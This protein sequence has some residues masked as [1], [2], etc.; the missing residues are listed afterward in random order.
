MGYKGNTTVE[1]TRPQRS[2]F[3]MSQERRLS[4]RMGRLTQVYCA[5]VLPGDYWWGKTEIMMRLAPLLAPIFARVNVFVHWHFVPNRLLWKDWEPFITGGRLGAEVSV[6]PVPPNVTLGFVGGRAKSLMAKSTLSNYLGIPPMLD[7]TAIAYGSRSIDLMPFAANY[8]IW[9]DWYRDRNYDADDTILPLP[10]G[11]NAVAA[12][13]DAL[14][15]TRKRSWESDYF[16]SAQTGTQ[17]GSE[18]LMPI[19]A[20]GNATPTYLAQAT[21]HDA[22]GSLQGGLVTAAGTPGNLQVSG[23][24]VVG[25]RGIRN[26]ASIAVNVTSSSVSINDFRQ[27]YAIQVWLERNQLAGSRMSESIQAHFATR[28]SDQRLQYAEYLGGGKTPVQISEVVATAWSND[29]T[30]DVP[31]G[32]MAG[33]GISYSAN[34]NSFKYSAEEWGFLVATMSVMPRT[35]YKQGLPRMFQ[36]RSTFLDY[37]W[38][39]FANLGEQEVYNW[40]VFLSTT[41]MTVLRTDL[42]LFGYQSRYSDWKQMFSFDSGDFYDN[43]EFWTLT[44]KFATQPVLGKT[45]VEFDDELNDQIFAVAAVDTLWCYLYNDVKVKRA[46]P[47]F[48]T[49]KLAN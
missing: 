25:T 16:T 29:G 27:A 32:N 38:P 1:L 34:N 4:T 21:V 44:R 23:T 35:S 18:V 30:T 39:T 22:A 7:A 24:Q 8:R 13:I 15:A 45:F 47:Y 28:T 31:Q 17:R 6:P 46:L 5:E 12:T 40:E 33:K 9:Y 20:S 19:Q 37:P 43:L 41:S 3:D 2:T 11:V 10:S 26:I 49:P 42:P 36:Q 48:G 14:M